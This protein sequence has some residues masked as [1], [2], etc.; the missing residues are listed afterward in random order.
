M[1]RYTTGTNIYTN[2]C[3]NDNCLAGENFYRRCTCIVT[4]K[5]E[6]K[7]VQKQ[8]N[9][10]IICRNQSTRWAPVISEV[11]FSIDMLVLK[12]E[13]KSPRRELNS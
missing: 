5:K 6:T 13:T 2:C 1:N 12:K 8:P 7:M 4:R 9:T 10:L 3:T 11:S